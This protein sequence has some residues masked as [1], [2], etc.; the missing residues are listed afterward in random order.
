MPGTRTNAHPV[1]HV[2]TMYVLGASTAV[3]VAEMIVPFDGQIRAVAAYA[4]TAGVGAGNTVLDLLKNGTT[5]YT[6]AANRPTLLG[7]ATGE[8]AN[9]VPDVKSVQKGDRIRWIVATI[10]ATTGHA[11][12]MASAVIE[13]A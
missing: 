1:R 8:F 6:T 12:L 10:P 11:R 13:Q 2:F 4:E 3:T 7:T 5:M 9:T